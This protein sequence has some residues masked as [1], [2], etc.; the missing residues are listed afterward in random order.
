MKRLFIL[1]ITLACSGDPPSDGPRGPDTPP[2]DYEPPVALNADPP[3]V[4]PLDLFERRIE[5]TVRLRL[6]LL[7]DGTVVPESTRIEEPSGHA[8]L[9]A[10]ALSGVAL[11]TFAPARR[12]GVPVETAFIQ[13]IEF[14]H[15]EGRTTT[16][17]SEHP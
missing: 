6:Y 10:A 1:L 12:M 11:M 4:Y 9:D 17:E 8:E 13:P 2:R 5:G 15:P 7:D 3:V 16:G 14:R